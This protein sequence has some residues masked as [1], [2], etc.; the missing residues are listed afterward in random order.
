MH[1]RGSLIRS[2]ALD[3]MEGNVCLPVRLFKCLSSCLMDCDDMLNRYSWSEEEESH[4]LQWSADISCAAKVSPT[5]HSELRL[6]SV[7]QNLSQWTEGHTAQ[8]V[9]KWREP[10][11]LIPFSNLPI[12]DRSFYFVF[13]PSG[14][15]LINL[16]FF[17]IIWFYLILCVCK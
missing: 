9:N 3:F 17:L 10:G 11:I 16:L 4:W 8:E 5:Y 14:L 13:L 15:L 2:S 1:W 12:D 6:I 7:F